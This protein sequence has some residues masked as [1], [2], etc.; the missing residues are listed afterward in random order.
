MSSGVQRELRPDIGEAELRGLF[1]SFIVLPNK[2]WDED[3]G[4]WL[5]LS[6]DTDDEWMIIEITMAT[7]E[8]KPHGPG[9]AWR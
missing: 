1:T 8:T 2:H 5:V 7:G 4:K 9:G 3:C 6:A